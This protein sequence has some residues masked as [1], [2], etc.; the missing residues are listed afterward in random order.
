MILLSNLQNV[1]LLAEK[2]PVA[3]NAQ[4]MLTSLLPL[5][6]LF[7][8]MYFLLIKPQKK[9]QKEVE[10][11]RASLKPGNRI[12]TIGG[13][14][15]KIKK[16]TEDEIYIVMSEN[17]E[18]VVIKKWAVQSVLEKEEAKEIEKNSKKALGE[19]M[20]ELAEEVEE[21]ADLVDEKIEDVQDVTFE[22]VEKDQ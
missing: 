17:S 18:H 4:S 21:T 5:I 10:Q 22:E 8:V 19:A 2:E 12:V 13:F 6:L 16:I 14:V 11:M 9:K 7:V 1:L 15:G 3:N 20:P